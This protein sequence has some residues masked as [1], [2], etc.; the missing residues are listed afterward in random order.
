MN[1]G[2]TVP[3]VIGVTGGQA[4]GHQAPG[5]ASGI[6]NLQGGRGNASKDKNPLAAGDA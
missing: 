5:D 4:K 2:M 3:F 1:E 6:R